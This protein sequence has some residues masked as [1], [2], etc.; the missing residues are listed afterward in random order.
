MR[1]RDRED[2]VL[3]VGIGCVRICTLGASWCS[4]LAS[5]STIVL[6]FD[7]GTILPALHQHDC[8]GYIL[9]MSGHRRVNGTAEKRADEY[10]RRRIL[11]RKEGEGK[12]REE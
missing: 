6:S 4:V 1:Q 7:Q 2:W 9:E 11:Q 8:H 3:Q 5:T 12:K 10:S